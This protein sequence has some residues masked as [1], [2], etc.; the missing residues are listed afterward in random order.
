M[1]SVPT[2]GTQVNRWIE[3]LNESMEMI[4]R[5]FAFRTHLAMRAFAANYPDQSEQGI[6]FAMADQVEQK[7]LPKF[8]GLDPNEENVG[9]SL[10]LVVALL[11]EWGDGALISAVESARRDGT[12]EHQFIF[13]GVDRG[14]AED[15]ETRARPVD[16]AKIVAAVRTPSSDGDATPREEEPGK[17]PGG[18]STSPSPHRPPLDEG[19][20]ADLDD[21]DDPTGPTGARRSASPERA[22]LADDVSGTSSEEPPPPRDASPRRRAS[23]AS[24]SPS[25]GGCAGGRS[26][27]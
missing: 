26:S 24:P 27:V 19:L 8:R 6:R 21:L 7:I 5:P 15:L 1:T 2:A 23:S 25:P 11:D 20:A 16:V 9:R 13:R 18:T 3:E 10:D 14:A 12:R 22:E 4:R 17:I